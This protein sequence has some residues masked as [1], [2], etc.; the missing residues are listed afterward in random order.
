MD[1]NKYE[2]PNL[3]A[4]YLADYDPIIQYTNKIVK[5]KE[6][7]DLGL[8]P[9]HMINN[10][11]I[12]HG[13]IAGNMRVETYT[14]EEFT[15][16]HE[17]LKISLKF[18]PEM[19]PKISYDG[20]L[21]YKLFDSKMISEI[22]P[23]FKSDTLVQL[24]RD[25]EA[26][27]EDTEEDITGLCYIEEYVDNLEGFSITHIRKKSTDIENR[28]YTLVSPSRFFT[29]NELNKYLF[30]VIDVDFGKIYD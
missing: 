18:R 17:G 29:S 5:S 14:D 16:Y 30:K 24:I 12:R 23:E 11:S 19:L 9:T 7:V 3:Y 6:C 10:V 20:K 2:F 4:E 26:D 21:F 1:V 8:K 25:P 13:D 27:F 28:P 15:V 22:N